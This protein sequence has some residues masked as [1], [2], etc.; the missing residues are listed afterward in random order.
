MMS[1]FVPLQAYLDTLVHPAVRAGGRGPAAADAVVVAKHRGFIGSRLTGGAC[2]LAAL[3][4]FLAVRGAPGAVE[5]MIFA[6]LVAPIGIAV[7]LSRTGR[8][9]V[10]HLMSALTLAGLVAAVAAVTGGLNAF[11][12]PWLLV[13]PLESAFTASR[14]VAAVAAAAALSV[15]FGLFAA[16]SLHLLPAPR[17]ELL[18][19]EWLRLFGLLTAVLYAAALAASATYIGETGEQLVRQQEARYHLLA[20]NMTDVITR[21]ARS[22][23]A[24]FV[25][26]GARELFGVPSEAL[27][28]NGLFERVHVADRP[29]YLRALAN[30]AR[31]GTGAIEFRVRRGPLDGGEPVF[32]WVEMRARA[33]DDW[34]GAGRDGTSG[35]QVVAVTR[36]ISERKRTEITLADAREVAESADLAKTRFLASMSHELRT[37]LNAIIGF[38][39]ILM[40]GDEGKVP[41]ERRAGYARLIHESGQHLLSVVNGIL[42][43]SRIES[44][45]FELLPESFE[46]APLLA[47]CTSMVA[48]KAEEAGIK[49]VTEVDPALGE[50]VLDKR[51]LR[52]IVINLLSNA[53]KFTPAGGSIRI[54]ARASGADLMLRVTDTGIGIAE[55]DLMRLGQP[56]FQARSSYDRPY[57]GSGLGLSVVKGLVA[58]HGGTVEIGSR[59]GEGTSVE[60]R[61]PLHMAAGV[62]ER[63]KI[64]RLPRRPSSVDTADLLKKRA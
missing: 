5:A 11:V 18:E 24:V 27:L 16:D 7:Y 19:S 23:D 29:A 52:Q 36:D 61:L 51:A 63:P 49:V 45:G 41:A 44:G 2:A 15:A 21:H 56:F 48:L 1:V 6:W 57:E 13:I 12:I 10:A 62:E 30:A 8:F 34:P 26:P 46:L 22:G 53:V 60:V 58:L 17:P 42:D 4:V 40:A 25:S 64:A 33:V 37:P 32:I 43:L 55:A 14:R 3:P 9:E 20:Q 54:V 39:E 28:N 50:L 35:R 38:S 47:G 59:V 31:D